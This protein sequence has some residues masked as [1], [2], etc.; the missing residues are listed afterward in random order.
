V[1]TAG[2]FQAL[3]ELAPSTERLKDEEL[4]EVFNIGPR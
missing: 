1:T 4:R 2:S 3:D